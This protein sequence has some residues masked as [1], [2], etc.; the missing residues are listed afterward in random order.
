MSSKYQKV[1]PKPAK[2][3]CKLQTAMWS[4]RNFIIEIKSQEREL[5]GEKNGEVGMGVWDPWH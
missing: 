1:E 5:N 4:I 3:N 2:H